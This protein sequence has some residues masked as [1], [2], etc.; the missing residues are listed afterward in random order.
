MLLLLLDSHDVEAVAAASTQAYHLSSSRCVPWIFHCIVPSSLSEFGSNAYGT[1]F[2]RELCCWSSGSCFCSRPIIYA[3]A[4]V[5]PG[6]LSVLHHASSTYRCVCRGFAS[7]DCTDVHHGMIITIVLGFV[8][9]WTRKLT[10]LQNDVC[11]CH[12]TKSP[13]LS[14]VWGLLRL[15]LTSVPSIHT[16]MRPSPHM[17]T[18]TEK[19]YKLK[20]HVHTHVCMLW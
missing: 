18:C 15:A 12:Q 19:R 20:C 1:T 13:W 5:G 6:L 14:Y 3:V 10:H 4:T 8:C 17:Y 9:R 7:S 11:A 16:C 2:A